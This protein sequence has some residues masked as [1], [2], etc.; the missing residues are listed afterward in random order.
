M[1]VAS[2]IQQRAQLMTSQTAMCLVR[3]KLEIPASKLG[4]GSCDVEARAQGVEM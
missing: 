4:K 2:A 3:L 1:T